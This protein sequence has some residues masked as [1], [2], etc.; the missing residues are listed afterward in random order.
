MMKLLK[1]LSIGAA[2][3]MTFAAASAQS[4]AP[5]ASSDTTITDIIN[6]SGVISVTH[7][8]ALELRLR[9]M[10]GECFRQ[11]TQDTGREE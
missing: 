11:K 1:Q 3:M 5:A 8:E 6:R 7:P 2:L 10:A 9:K 4:P